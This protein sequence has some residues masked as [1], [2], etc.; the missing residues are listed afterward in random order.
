VQKLRDNPK[1]AKQEYSAI[2]DETDP[3]ITPRLTF[4]PSPKKYK[5]RPR[6]AIFR[7]QGING[8]IEMAAAFDK[9]GFDA[10]D[11]HLMDLISGRFNLADFSLLAV[12]G[13]FSYG[14]VL[15]A[16]EGWAKSILFNKSLKLQ[17]KDFFERPDTLALGICNGCQMLA[18][19]KMLIPGAAHWP[20]FLHNESGRFEARLVS[21][22]V[23]KTPS[24]FFK[25]MQ[26][27]VLP[28][29]VAHG[30]GR[31]VFT[32]KKSCNQ[33]LTEHLA[34]L[35]YV[36]NSGQVTTKYPQNPNGSDLGITSLTSK[37]GRATILM[38][39]PERVFLTKQLSWHPGDWPEESPWL[40]IFQNAR[41]WIS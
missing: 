3:G 40:K 6:A 26:G 22:R 14:D 36:D 28:V 25:G 15:G 17:F 31:A 37:D 27:A 13:G 30:E 24:V 8:Q 18:A 39:H 41:D 29:P 10:V 34:P 11:V 5:S 35:Q 21:V 4:K 9:A 32:D 7:E 1:L 38:P 2:H 19:L 12:C 23:N 33:I 20:Q 16:G